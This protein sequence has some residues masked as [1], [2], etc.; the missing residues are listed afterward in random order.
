LAEETQKCLGR[1]SFTGLIRKEKSG[2]LTH[3]GKEPEKKRS[4]LGFEG[5][6]F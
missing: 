3:M 4:R 6:I 2:K 1:N 5:F